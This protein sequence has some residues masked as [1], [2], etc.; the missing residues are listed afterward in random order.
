M[1]RSVDSYHSGNTLPFIARYRKEAI[2]S[3]DETQLR[4]VAA[5]LAS[6]DSLE[7]QRSSVL[8]KLQKLVCVCGRCLGGVVACC[9][10]GSALLEGRLAAP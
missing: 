5:K 4:S 7:E 10:A 1:P 3:M 6:L 9:T 8:G 2:G